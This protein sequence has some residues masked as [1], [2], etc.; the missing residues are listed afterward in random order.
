MKICKDCGKEFKQ[1]GRNHIRCTDCKPI[2]E[3]NMNRLYDRKKWYKVE[4]G[5][6]LEDY[7]NMFQS[8][9]GCCAICGTHQTKFAK[10]LA[11]DHC[12]TSKNVRGLLCTKCNL[13]LGYASDNVEILLS[14]IN[15]LKKGS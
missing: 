2:H 12:H 7:N 9:M 11:V 15:Y 6:T 10:G 4:Y 8:Q 1:T 14:A 3:R 5:I 13:L